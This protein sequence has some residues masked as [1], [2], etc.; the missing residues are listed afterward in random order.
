MKAPQWYE[1]QD[2]QLT[3]LQ[4][5]NQGYYSNYLTLTAQGLANQNRSLLWGYFIA[6]ELW[7]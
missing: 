1:C 5:E 2:R 6:A 7:E 4:G 3:S